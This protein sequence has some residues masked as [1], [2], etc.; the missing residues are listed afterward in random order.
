MD[1]EGDLLG[2][3]YRPMF[4]CVFLLN[5]RLSVFSYS[6]CALSSLLVAWNSSS[7]MTTLLFN[8]DGD[9]YTLSTGIVL[10]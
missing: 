9:V 4:L 1:L 2:V 10:V 3:E 8:R 6:F 5:E 7:L